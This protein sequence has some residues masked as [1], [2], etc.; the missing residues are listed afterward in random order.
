[1]TS[2]ATLNRGLRIA[3]ILRVQAEVIPRLWIPGIKPQRL[4]E[5]SFSFIDLLEIQK[6]DALI[7]SCNRKLGI[8]F[9]GLL[10]GFQRLL[11]KLLVHVRRAQVIQP[12]GLSG[13]RLRLSLRGGREQA[14]CSQ[15]HSGQGN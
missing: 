6:S 5:R 11:E 2:L 14:K 13:I 7:Q 8:E 15:E 10:E 9:S 1:M 12:R 4:F 3:R